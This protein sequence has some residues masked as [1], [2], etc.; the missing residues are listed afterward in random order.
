MVQ[1]ARRS[2]LAAAAL[3]LACAAAAAQDAVRAGPQA[4]ERGPYREQ[5]WRIP[6]VDADGTTP[7]LLEALLF[8]PPGEG[9]RP[10]VVISHG[11]PRRPED[12]AGM[13]PHWAERAAAF[14]VAEG[15]VVVAAMRR[16]YGR[17]PGEADERTP[18][19]CGNPDYVE[20]ARRV[21]KQVLAVAAF[22]RAQP[23][24]AGDK[25]V[26]AGQSAGGLASIAAAA[27]NPPGIVGVVNFAGGRG[28]RATD[29]VC[30]EDR[31]VAAMQRFGQGSRV[32]SIWLYSEND[33]YFRPDLAR[34]MHTAYAPGLA[35]A[36]ART[37]LH[38]LPPFG[39]DGHGFVLRAESERHWHPLV[40]EFLAS[41]GTGA[42]RAAVPP[43][44]DTAPRFERLVPGGAQ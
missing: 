42:V 23:F 25:I 6:V 18:G 15:Y 39:Q 17:S 36:G 29:D 4:P 30:G 27:D 21:A 35:A 43:L 3:A 1:A 37:S 5:L 9:R 20:V 8:R 34:R 14:F 19:G 26:L 2:C 10:L 38:I 12:R 28:S 7:R 11:T 44:P 22:M 33:T 41:L 32:P 13:R 40:R 16:G 31:L 24:V